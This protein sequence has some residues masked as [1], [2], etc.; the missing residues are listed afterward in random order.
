MSK[1]KRRRLRTGLW[2]TPTVEGITVT[3]ELDD[4]EDTG[5]YAMNGGV[6]RWLGTERG[7]MIFEQ[8]WGVDIM[9]A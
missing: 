6:E 3:A 8:E 4:Q 1:P 2:G 9:N 7:L 5:R